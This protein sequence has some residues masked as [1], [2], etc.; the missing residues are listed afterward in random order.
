MCFKCEG[1]IWPKWQGE[2]AAPGP[3]ATSPQGIRLTSNQADQKWR[4]RADS[5][6]LEARTSRM[7]LVGYWSWS[8]QTACRLPVSRIRAITYVACRCLSLIHISEPTRLGMIS[9]AVFCL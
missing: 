4:E 3:P 7:T 1:C 5:C 6:L 2:A 8:H 9:Y